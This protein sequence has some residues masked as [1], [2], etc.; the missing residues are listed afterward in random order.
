MVAVVMSYMS[1][2]SV[3]VSAGIFTACSFLPIDVTTASP[4]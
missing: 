4:K 1:P 3:S 2:R